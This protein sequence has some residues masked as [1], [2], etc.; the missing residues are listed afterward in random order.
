MGPVG[1]G[2]VVDL[3]CFA[4]RSKNIVV[5]VGSKFRYDALKPELAVVAVLDPFGG[6]EV[7]NFKFLVRL[8]I[9]NNDRSGGLN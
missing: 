9:V 3:I 4:V 2:V 6:L 8:R 7:A 5:L 1:G